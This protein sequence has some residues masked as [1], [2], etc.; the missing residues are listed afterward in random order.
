MQNLR[1]GLTFICISSL[2]GL[3]GCFSIYDKNSASNYGSRTGNAPQDTTR[4]YQTEQQN[5]IVS[6]RH[7]TLQFNQALGEKVAA[8][9]GV[10]SC[11]VMMAD[12]TAYVAILIDN[13]ASGTKSG[14][15]ETNN[16]GTVR[17][18]YNPSTPFNDY[19]DPNLLTNGSNNY[20]TVQYHDQIT[21][22]F[23]Q[24]IAEKIRSLQPNVSD[25]Y[26]SANRDYVNELNRLAQEAWGGHDLTPY[27]PEFDAISERIFGTLPTIPTQSEQ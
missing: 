23:K 10:N 27:L 14:P 13:T 12:K 18:L 15:M 17:G 26:I 6:H 19:M 20:E 8:M 21:H 5:S 11:I 9:N 22:L 25:V 7:S 4:A 24:K 3:C 2:L 1:L 16:A